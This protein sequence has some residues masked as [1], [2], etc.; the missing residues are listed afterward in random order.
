M[1]EQ[2][3]LDVNSF[4]NVSV[5]GISSENLKSEQRISNFLDKFYVGFCYF[6]LI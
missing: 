3:E 6:F 1:A 5:K 4:F 2:G